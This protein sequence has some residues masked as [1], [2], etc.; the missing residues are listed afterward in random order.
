MKEQEIN[1]KKRREKKQVL[2]S[3]EYKVGKALIDNLG[4]YFN[5]SDDIWDILD[6]KHTKEKVQEFID[7]FLENFFKK[8]EDLFKIFVKALEILE[9]KKSLNK[10]FNRLSKK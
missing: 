1:E 7:Y 4:R 3:K 6:D 10:F 8:L 2:E 5:L 9:N